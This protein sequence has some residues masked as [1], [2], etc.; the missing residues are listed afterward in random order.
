MNITNNISNI[1]SQK[2][3]QAKTSCNFS[4]TSKLE[5][6]PSEDCFVR[7]TNLIKQISDKQ[8][9]EKLYDETYNQVIN[10]VSKTNPIIKD[11]EL[12]KPQIIIKGYS[13]SKTCGAYSFIDNTISISKDVF[14]ISSYIIGTVDKDGNIEKY[15]GLTSEKEKQEKLKKA[16]QLENNAEL[17]KLS[18]EEQDI[19]VKSVFAHEIRHFI[20]EHLI[21]STEG[22]GQLQK[23]GINNFKNDVKK[24]REEY[25][26]LCKEAGIEPDKNLIKEDKK[27]YETYRPKINLPAD[28]K[29]KFDYSFSTCCV[30]F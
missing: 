9:I 18:K 4:A 22:C 24:A 19:Y 6:Q 8:R 17:I 28:T 2:I 7:S 27:Y 13:D 26:N 5:F 1:F 25:I 21:A 14:D 10:L 15:L 29:L 16:Q 20:Q 30:E 11:L 23:D 12:N 3:Q